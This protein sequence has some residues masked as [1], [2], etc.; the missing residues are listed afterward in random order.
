MCEEK[1]ENLCVPG[2]QKDF[3]VRLGVFACEG[4]RGGRKG[5]R[6][7]HIYIWQM[8]CVCVLMVTFVLA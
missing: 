7:M 3:S 8:Y 4:E 2:E 5:E 6:K 1:T